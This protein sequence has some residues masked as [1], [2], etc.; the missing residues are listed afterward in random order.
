MRIS[1][2]P[3]NTE[4]T[5]KIEKTINDILQKG[6]YVSGLHDRL[7]SKYAE[8][9][10]LNSKLVFDANGEPK[11]IKLT[12]NEIC[13]EQIVLHNEFVSEIETTRKIAELL[14]HGYE[15]YRTWSLPH[16]QTKIQAF[17]YYKLIES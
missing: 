15:E 3:S 6:E 10:L 16:I 11:A 8:T 1:I 2:Y 7:G 14:S 5:E 17:R 13:K 4:E 9:K 12:D